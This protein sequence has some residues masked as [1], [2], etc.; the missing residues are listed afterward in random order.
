MFKKTCTVRLFLFF[1]L[2]SL[3]LAPRIQADILGEARTAWGLAVRV[4]CEHGSYQAVVLGH[5]LAQTEE[6]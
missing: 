2:C 4:R 5:C 3:V 1:D 6:S